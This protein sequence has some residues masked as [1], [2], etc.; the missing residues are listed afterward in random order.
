[1]RASRL[2]GSQDPTSDGATTL[3]RLFAS[4]TSVG[5]VSGEAMR[6][7]CDAGPLVL[8]RDAVAVRLQTAGALRRVRSAADRLQRQLL[9]VLRR[10][11][12][13]VVAGEALGAGRR[14]RGAGGE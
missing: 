3:T 9:R 6:S 12:D 10:R 2:R 11:D 5:I 8:R 4:A 1:M 13:R 14:Q 7:V